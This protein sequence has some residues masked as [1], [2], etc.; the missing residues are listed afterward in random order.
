MS[1]NVEYILV[2]LVVVGTVLLSYII[3]KHC[4]G[5]RT[6]VKQMLASAT[7]SRSPEGDRGK[8]GIRGTDRIHRSK[9]FG[10]ANVNVEGDSFQMEPLMP[11]SEFTIEDEE[12]TILFHD[13]KRQK[14]L[15]KNSE[16]KS[17]AYQRIG[18]AKPNDEDAITVAKSD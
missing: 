6:N 11:I 8:G 2:A 14:T 5:P 4:V 7:I 16:S 10:S 12:D 3:Y 17:I 13:I 9:M 1:E 15:S 18:E